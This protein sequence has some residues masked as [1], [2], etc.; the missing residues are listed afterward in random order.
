MKSL[1]LSVLLCLLPVSGQAQTLAVRWAH[2]AVSQSYEVCLTGQ[3]CVVVTA[4][5]SLVSGQHEVTFGPLA[6]GTYTATVKAI[7]LT[8]SA[9][10]TAAVTI[11]DVVSPPPP[12]APPT[13]ACYIDGETRL[14]PVRLSYTGGLTREK[15][16]AAARAKGLPWAGVEYSS[17]C[18]GGSVAPPDSAK[19]PDSECSMKCS[20]D[21]TQIC[22]GSWRLNLLDAR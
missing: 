17:E 2:D 14:L 9:T 18:F 12:P 11:G 16:I 5:T 6:A 22:G 4:S 10:G 21:Q 7:N 3:P 13:A 1:V 19:R 15:C 20:G 8:A